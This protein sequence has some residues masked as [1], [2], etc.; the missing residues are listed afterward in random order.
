VD[1]GDATNYA[2]GN[3]KVIFANSSLRSNPALYEAVKGRASAISPRADSYRGFAHFKSWILSGAVNGESLD[4]CL[5]AFVHGGVSWSCSTLRKRLRVAS[6]SAAMATPHSS[7]SMTA[8]SLPMRTSS[9]APATS[10]RSPLNRM[11]QEPSDYFGNAIPQEK[12]PFVKPSPFEE[13]TVLP[14][15][16][17]Q[18]LSSSSHDATPASNG[19]LLA[20]TSADITALGNH[21]SFANECVLSASA[22]GHVD[23]FGSPSQDEIGFFDWTRLPYSDSLPRHIKFAR[24]IDWA[25]TSLGPIELWAP[26]L[27]QMCNLIMASPHPA[28]MY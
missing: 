23:K 16:E 9:D 26:D 14:S 10:S 8:P 25:S 7:S 28:G 6:A 15:V 11:H 13:R 24:S 1:L 19:A 3:L 4:L 21:S 20:T 27:R 5:P 18:E 22:A 17:L 12:A 2:P